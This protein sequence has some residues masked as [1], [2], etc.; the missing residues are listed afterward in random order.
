[1]SEDNEILFLG[2]TNSDE[3]S[4][5]DIEAEYMAALD[6]IER[7]RKRNK[8]LKEKP[9]KYQEE[10]NHIITDL[11]NQLQEA[12]RSEEY[13][14]VLLMKRIQYSEKV[15]KEIARLR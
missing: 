4:E 1:M 5:V 8:V 10:T 6:E 14:V 3:E 15:D 13:L 12:K 7:S 2:T 9:S 11:R